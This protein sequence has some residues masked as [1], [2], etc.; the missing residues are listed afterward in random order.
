MKKYLSILF[1]LSVYSTQSSA[2]GY[3][4]PEMSIKGMGMGNAFTAVADDASA[5]WFNPAAMAFQKDNMITAGADLIKPNNEFTKSGSTYESKSSTFF[6]PHA[7]LGYKQNDWPVTFG[8]AINSPFGLAMNWRNSGADFAK[9]TAG[10]ANVTFSEIRM[11]NLNPSI[12]YKLNN[13]WSIAAGITYF[14]VFEVHLDSLLADHEGDGDG[15]GHNLALMYKGDGYNVGLTY[16]SK[17]KANISGTVVK[18]EIG[19]DAGTVGNVTTSV[20]FPEMVNLGF[21]FNPSDKWLVSMELDWTNW[22]R[23]ASIDLSYTGAITGT[24]LGN[25]SSIPEN[26][27]DTVAFRAGAEWQYRKNMRAR[28]G[29]VYDPTPINDADFSPRLPGNDRQ[30]ITFGY[31]YDLNTQT[32]LDFAYAY[33]WLDD[34]NQTTSAAVRNGL[35]ESDIHILSASLTYRF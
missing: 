7:Y 16:R 28:F 29:Y 35:Y 34:R 15:W 25:N 30:L 20:T 33:V 3:Q 11:I 10:A 4:I 21:S 19:G 12:A 13:Q 8:L 6:V 22:D 32:T 9:N 5:A 2:G 14:N 26:W 27:T 17:V 18:G 1:A 24:I 31:G 23:F